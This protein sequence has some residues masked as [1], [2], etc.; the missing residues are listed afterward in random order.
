M[1]ASLKAML[2]NRY[3]FTKGVRANDEYEQFWIRYKPTRVLR[4]HFGKYIKNQKIARI[5]S[6]LLALAAFLYFGPWMFLGLSCLIGVVF[7]AVYLRTLLFPSHVFLSEAGLQLHWLR[8][9]CNI[10]GPVI[11][12]D[13]LSHLSIATSRNMF[14]GVDSALEFNVLANG[15]PF[16]QR[17]I[18]HLLPPNMTSG[19]WNGDRCTIR[20]K[21]DGIAS[22][23]DRKRLQMALK[24]FLPSYRIDSSVTD[25]LNLA[26]RVESYTDLW[27]DALSSSKRIRQDMLEPGTHI[28]GG[29]YE[30]DEHIGGGGQA[31]VY[32]AKEK[33]S[34]GQGAIKETQ[35]V[36]KEFILPAQAGVNVRKRVLGNIQRE[37]NILK[38]L[39][40]SNIVRFIDFFVDDQRAYLVLEHI[41]GITLQRHIESNGCLTEHETINLSLQ[42]CEILRNLHSCT[43]PVIHRDFTPDNLMIDRNK[44]LKL[45]DFN[46]AEQLEASDT[47][48][49]VGKHAYIPP[50]QFRGKACEQ[51]DIYALGATMFYLLTAADP[52]PISVSVPQALNQLISDEL[53]SLV[54]RATAQEVSE[55]FKSWSAIKAE[56]LKISHER[57]GTS[58]S[59]SG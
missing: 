50:E 45:I 4:K 14:G 8:S 22:S 26:I 42:M 40:C 55:R 13:R 17:L 48:A 53:N 52:E 30:V 38:A 44:N 31:V 16:K 57:Y 18:Y 43:P 34:G 9:F 47:N 10:S 28:L 37:A 19:W 46:V 58:L 15:I 36:L 20:L 7:F 25:E 59:V 41:D 11:G 49:V 6:A 51:S 54:M 32:K 35:V 3:F 1:D 29:K 39:H 24:K 23:D 21:L 12:W 2:S 5:L 56:L 33:V 27:L